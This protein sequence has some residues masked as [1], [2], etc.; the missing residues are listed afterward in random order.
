MCEVY[1]GTGNVE[2]YT[3][4]KEALNLATTIRKS[5]RTLEK[6]LA[7]NKK[8][9]SK[10]FYAYV[11][12]KQKV[13]D[14]VGPLEDINGNTISDA[15]QMAE[16]LNEYFSSVFTTKDISSLP[17]PDAKY[18]DDQSDR[19]RQLFVTAEM[20]AKTIKKMKDYVHYTN[21]QNFKLFSRLNFE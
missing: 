4:Y 8:N 9:Y 14:T 20:I 15:F 13:R 16:V 12:S 3:N 11:R 18:E 19:L 17:V 5:K 6:K 2:D 7:G 1:K 10:S 21:V